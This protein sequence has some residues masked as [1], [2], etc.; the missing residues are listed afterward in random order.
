MA[1]THLN[2]PLTTS[3]ANKC[4]AGVEVGIYI[5]FPSGENT[6]LDVLTYPVNPLKFRLILSHLYPTTL[7]STLPDSVVLFV[8]VTVIVTV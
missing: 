8:Y 1:N 5:V 6:G 4:P 2:S 7:I 3:K